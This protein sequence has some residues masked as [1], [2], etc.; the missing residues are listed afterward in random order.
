MQDFKPRLNHLIHDILIRMMKMLPEDETALSQ[1]IEDEWNILCDDSN[2]KRIYT[3]EEKSNDLTITHE[4][5][6]LIFH[7]SYDE[8]ELLSRNHGTFINYKDIEDFITKYSKD[9]ECKESFYSLIHYIHGTLTQRAV[10][11]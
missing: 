10:L 3:F 11:S 1:L 7:L 2:L 6:F 4:G 8:L 5:F 9:A